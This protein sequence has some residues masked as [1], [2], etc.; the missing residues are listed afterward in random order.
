MQKILL[1][2]SDGYLFGCPPPG[3]VTADCEVEMVEGQRD[4]VGGGD[5][6]YL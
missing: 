2:D 1:E 4:A 3:K 6:V 5:T